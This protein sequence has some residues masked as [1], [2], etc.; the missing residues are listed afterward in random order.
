MAQPVQGLQ[1]GLVFFGEVEPDDVLHILLEEGGAGYGGD[2][3]LPGHLLAELHVGLAPFQVGANI[4]QDE[5]GA[6]GIGEGD[7]DIA[8]PVG[9]E[10]L[11]VGVVGPKL[12]IIA[13]RHLQT[14][15][16]GLHQRGG[17]A[18]GVEIVVLLDLV[19]NGLGRN[20]VANAPAGDGIGLGQGG[21]GDGPLPHAGHVA[22]IA[23]L[24]RGVDD[25]LIHLVHNGVHVVLDAQAGNQLQLLL[26]KH[27][28]A[29]VGGVADE[30]GLGV[31][32]EGILQ[33][34][35]VEVELRRHQRHIDGLAVGE[36]DLGVVVLKIGG[37][38]HHLVPGV[39]EGKDGVHHGLGGADGYHHLSVRINVPAHK[40]LALFGQSPAE[41]GGTHGNRV[42]VGALIAHL[43]QTV[44]QRLGGIKV[45]K[46]LGQV[47]GVVGDGDT[48]HPAD[49][50]VGKILG[51]A[52][53]GLHISLPL[54]VHPGYPALPGARGASRSLPA[55]RPA[56]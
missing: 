9:E 55:E 6:L 33:H 35:G 19:H 7:A 52:A 51:L 16:G 4:R 36:E 22:H 23:V 42:L 8:Q 41:V 17:S 46:A 13:V 1:Q 45:G 2:P 25:V 44:H 37:E 18:H 24:V 38:Q 31:L 40:T 43:G 10:L 39:G 11:H 20:G 50:R 28:A 47:D 21:A 12:L 14:G 29:G 54:S 3:H 27:L 34:V 56:A 49:D 53:H 26:G 30:D 32:F 15:H 5:V 48:G